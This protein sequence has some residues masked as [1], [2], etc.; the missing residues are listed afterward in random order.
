MSQE[1]NSVLKAIPLRRRRFDWILLAF[2]TVNLLFI[3]YIIDIEQLTVADPYHFR[4]PVWPP[5]PFVDMVHDYGRHNDPLLMARPVFWRMTIWI[6]VIWNGPF[7][8]AAV[9]A[10]ARGREWIRVP[11]LLWCGTMS[12]V[13]LVILSEEYSG[14]Y[15]TPHFAFV[16]AVNVPWLL[17]PLGTAIRM[18]RQHPFTELVQTAP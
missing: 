2:F 1:T 16:L 11:A 3:T 18:A 14:L 5:K 10:L 8:V 15:K 17:L 6:D 13:V 7:Y 9:Y 4:Y 12:A